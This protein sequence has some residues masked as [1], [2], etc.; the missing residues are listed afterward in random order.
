M[1]MP[2]L[3]P[4][5]SPTF[6]ADFS[7][8]ALLQPLL[9]FLYFQVI[10]PPENVLEARKIAQ[11]AMTLTALCLTLI[12]VLGI[13]FSPLHQSHSSPQAFSA[14]PEK[15][16]L[17]VF[18]NRLMFPYILLISLV[19]LA[20]GILNADDHFLTPAIAPVL[21]NICMIGAAL[22]LTPLLR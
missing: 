2:F 4:S 8:R 18:L 22:C 10:W 16:E 5:G 20:M 13:I 1:L 11:T 6:Y 21:L 7:V 15:Y 19:A 3:S 14:T 9:S 17:A 12:T